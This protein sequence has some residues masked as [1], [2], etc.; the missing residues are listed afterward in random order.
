MEIKADFDVEGR[1]KATEGRVSEEETVKGSNGE[2]DIIV[3]DSK[4]GKRKEAQRMKGEITKAGDERKVRVGV[5]QWEMTKKEK[6]M[7]YCKVR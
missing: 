6:K 3:E 2:Q 7:K 1:Q 4:E 5:K